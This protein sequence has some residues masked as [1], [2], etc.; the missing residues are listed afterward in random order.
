MEPVLLERPS[1]GVAVLRINR[2]QVRGAL[3]RASIRL[4]VNMLREVSDDPELAAVVLSS[5]DPS[6]LCA[7]ADVNEVLDEEGGIS[8]MS[9]FAA[10]YAALESCPAVTICAMVGNT[11][12]AGAEL[13]AAC[14]LRVAG[15]N[16]KLRWVG[17][18][19]GVPVGP[20]RLTPLVGLAKARYLIL[21]SPVVSAEDALALN[22]T[23]E[24]V[25]A[26]ECHDRA[27]EIATSL[28]SRPVP[29]LRKVKG[30]FR[31][32]EETER[33]TLKENR[34]LLDFQRHGHGLPSAPGR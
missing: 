16:L 6:A 25:P 5:T 4:M 19:L 13:A 11:V 3:D 17:G 10:L 18:L 22:L 21:Q 27:V 8:R 33:R 14:D 20:A 2:P 30:L 7:G 26:A 23:F 31:E 1:P 12:G 15:D 32:F 24:I 34:V 29:N 9:E 28:A